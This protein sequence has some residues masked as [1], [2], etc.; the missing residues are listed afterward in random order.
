MGF[1]GMIAL[2]TSVLVDV[3]R[4]RQDVFQELSRIRQTHT[5]VPCLPFITTFEMLLRVQDASAQAQD[6][7]R[8]LLLRYPQLE[9]SKRTAEILANLRRKYDRKGLHLPFADLFSASQAIE[10]NVTLVTRD[11]DFERIEELNKIII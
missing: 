2:D 1:P 10:N 3:L 4:E 5:S 8:E 9:T 6:R 11:K 7:T